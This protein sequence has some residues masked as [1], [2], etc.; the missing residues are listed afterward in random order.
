MLVLLHKIQQFIHF[1]ELQ[2]LLESNAERMIGDEQLE[3]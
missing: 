3:V 1:I 2:D